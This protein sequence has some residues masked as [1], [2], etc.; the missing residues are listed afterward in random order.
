M[1]QKQEPI[2]VWD[3]AVR[4]FDWSLPVALVIEFAT[5][6][7]SATLHQ[8]ADLFLL[9]LV[10]FRLILRFVGS[11]YARF[12]NFVTPLLSASTI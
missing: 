8:Q 5:E 10:L 12:E 6:E 11:R 3:L 4:C 1:N 2:Q 7:G 9:A